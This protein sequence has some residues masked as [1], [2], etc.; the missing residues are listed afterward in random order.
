MSPGAQS[1][2]SEKLK[3]RITELGLTQ[4]EVAAKAGIDRID[5]NRMVNGKREP[6]PHEVAMLAR[7][8]KIDA[9]ELAADVNQDEVKVFSVL[10]ER[11]ITAEERLAE[12]EREREAVVQART[13]AE[14]RWT[15]EREELIEE[16]LV[17]KQ[18]AASRIA[19]IEA[20]AARREARLNLEVRQQTEA[21][22]QR[23]AEITR[24]QGVIAANGQTMAELRQRLAGEGG[25]A[26]FAGVVGALAGALLTKSGD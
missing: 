7:V 18:E 26:I 20:D 8:L 19:Q 3:Q 24:L 16:T 22:A 23:D 9:E 1:A 15:T 2:F 25:R 12:S 17:A 5:L 11:V 14:A 6:K 21:V 4:T 10:A 13:A